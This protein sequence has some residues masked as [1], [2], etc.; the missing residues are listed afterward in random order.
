MNTDLLLRDHLV[1]LLSWQSAHVG[2]DEAIDGIPPER[3]GQQP[4][5]LPFSLWQLLEHLRLAQF[6]ILDFCRNPDYTEGVWPDDYW[7]DTIAPPNPEAWDASLAQFRADRQAMQELLGDAGTDLYTPIPHGDGQT[8]LR[9]AVLLADHNAY[10][11]GQIVAVRRLLGI[12]PPR[13]EA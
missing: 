5:G 3:R 11:V 6:D 10:H 9:E 4:E 8:I 12:W 13:H 1:K 7:P 2:F